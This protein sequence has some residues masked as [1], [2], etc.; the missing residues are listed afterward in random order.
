MALRQQLL[1]DWEWIWTYD[2][3]TQAHRLIGHDLMLRTNVCEQPENKYVSWLAELAFQSPPGVRVLIQESWR[4]R[5]LIEGLSI[6]IVGGLKA[7]LILYM[8]YV[9]G[10]VT[11][12]CSQL[13]KADDACFCELLPSVDDGSQ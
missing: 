8:G 6:I 11:A 9:P 4:E 5:A 1:Q 7:M 13:F 2:D 12:K 3:G 10:I